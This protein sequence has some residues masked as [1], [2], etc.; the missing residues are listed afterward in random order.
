MGICIDLEDQIWCHLGEDHRHLKIGCAAIRCWPVTD[1]GLP[2]SKNSCCGRLCADCG[3]P[4][5]RF[6]YVGVGLQK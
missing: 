1:I 5:L 2:D 4:K 6:T 3:G